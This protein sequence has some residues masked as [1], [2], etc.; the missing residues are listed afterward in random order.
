MT[1]TTTL[2]QAVLQAF[3][4]VPDLYLILS[5]ELQI[6]T[7]SDA[8][9][10]ATGTVREAIVG[11][12]FS[13]VLDGKAME[14]G[15]IVS[16]TSSLQQALQTGQTQHLELQQC[17]KAD[18]SIPNAPVHKYWK[19]LNSPVTDEQGEV[20]YII[21]RLQQ[22]TEQ[23]YT[24][25]SIVPATT[26]RST[27]KTEI[28]GCYELDLTTQKIKFSDELSRLFGEERQSFGPSMDF[29]NRRTHPDDLH[30]IKAVIER[31]V[32]HNTPYQ[33]TRR[34]QLPDGSLRT[35]EILGHVVC[36]DAGQAVKLIG[37]VHDATDR[38]KAE[39]ELKQNEELLKTTIDSSLDMIQVFEAVR[40]EN[41]KIVDFK[42]ILNNHTSEEIYGDV[43]GKSLLTHNPGVLR[44]GIFDTFRQVV[45]TG[46]PDQSERH[47]T[48]EQFD[49]WFH[50]STV[51]L[52]DGVATT[53]HDITQR[54][55]A[56]QALQQSKSLLQG[57]L[58]APNVGMAV[59]KAVRD[60]QGNILDF[61][62]EFINRRTLEALGGHDMT[63]QL[64]SDHGEAG[65]LQIAEFS[66]VLETG[67]ANSY[68]IQR[69]L[70]GLN[71]WI[72]ISNARLDAERLVHVWDDITE[73][74]ENEQEVLRLKDEVAQQATDK[75]HNLFN[76]MDEGYCIIQ[77]LY[78]ASGTAVDFQYLEVNQAFE[79]NTGLRAVAGKTIR[80][81]APDIEPKWIEIYDQVAKSGIPLRF[82]EASEALQ[83]IFSLYAFRIGEP[84]ERTVAVIFSDIT[85]RKKSQEALR[86]SEEQFRLFVTASSDM[87]YKIS[88]D[89]SQLHML[90]GRNFLPEPEEPTNYWF[91][92]Y[93]PSEG[94]AFVTA[95]V[96]E[97]IRTKSIF[98]LEHQVYKADGTVGW[99]A[100]RAIPVL[101]EQGNIKEWFGTASDIT[102]RKQ[103][104]QQLQELN[105]SLEQ[106]VAERTHELNESKL[107]AEQITEATPDFIMIFNLLSNKVEFVN[108][109]PYSG[110]QERYQET[111]QIDYEQLMSRSHP[112]DRQKLQEF[113]DRF[114]TTPDHEA[115][116]LEYRVSD[117]E[118]A[119]WY[120]SRGKVFRRD[121]SGKPT[122]FISVVQDINELKMLEEENLQMRLDQQRTN[123]LTILDAQEEE[124]RRISEGLHNGVGQI[125]YTAKLHLSHYLSQQPKKDSQA[126]PI[127]QVEQIL[128]EAIR[129][130]R[131]LSHQ[132]AP[133]L[134]EQ[135][136]LETAFKEIGNLLSNSSLQMQCLVYNLP[137]HLDKHLQLV[138]YRV[139]QEMANNIIRH[140]QATEA[141]LLLRAQ[142]QYLILIAEDNGRGFNPAVSLK[143]GIGLS[144]IKNRV[145]LLNGT[146]S[147]NTAPGLGTQVKITLPL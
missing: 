1:S 117:D 15:A 116:T 130:T 45:E 14:V 99:I 51:K 5:P 16:L 72:L 131:G 92:G 46:I 94:R 146:F 132:L 66:S 42:W 48:Y 71:R 9:L 8:Y 63:G 28:P 124:R 32:D 22:V 75:Y 97:A 82:E 119:I 110:N 40:D 88:A 95:K 93:I 19:V 80:E 102:L 141:S 125:L 68:V 134:L 57:I 49:G 53:T 7:A 60:G 77:L 10:Q 62:H 133:A 64:L 101:D 120:R 65:S 29:V 104:E 113:I 13:E 21:H 90:T 12:G 41:G 108:Q 35:L 111:L 24:Q 121:D 30:V 115:Y 140:A 135:F 23:A 100:S 128:D 87:I 73:Q 3:E 31:A 106:L 122:H 78:D 56:E 139:A 11:R 81:L 54:K 26:R 52:H 76:S 58:D 98:E 69:E 105:E 144:S 47:Y 107:F 55:K 129:Q 85:E 127:R 43:V 33:Y 34:I 37:L 25:R 126:N 112:E 18:N 96:R 79:R 67:Q 38:T 86:Q 91:D 17:E 70:L 143:K 2:H 39:Q 145:E 83:H 50:Q 123:L 136:G 61:V 59:Y 44:E 36:N 137:K 74:K 89:W 6:L 138:V 114:R 118:K 84:E 4:Q 20:A 27:K 109:N 142:R 147:L 103:A